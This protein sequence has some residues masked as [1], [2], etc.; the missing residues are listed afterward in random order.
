MKIYIVKLNDYD[1]DE[2]VGFFTSYDKAEQ[3]RDYLNIYNPSQ[4][5]DY[6]WEIVEYKFDTTDYGELI[7]KHE[8]EVRLK[9]IK[10]NELIRNF[11]LKELE[12]LKNKYE[13]CNNGELE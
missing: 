8:K 3:C 9:L 2:S 4:Y 5:E 7:K 6:K 12:R 11:E 1:R 13:G 10:E